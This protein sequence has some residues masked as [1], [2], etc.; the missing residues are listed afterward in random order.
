[1]LQQELVVAEFLS[2]GSSS[3][4]CYLCLTGHNYM[5]MFIGTLLIKQF[6]ISYSG[7]SGNGIY[8]AIKM[9]HHLHRFTL[10]ISRPGILSSHNLL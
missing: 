7:E 3:G 4:R 8:I 2:L 5:Q 10:K 9:M 6:K 1:M